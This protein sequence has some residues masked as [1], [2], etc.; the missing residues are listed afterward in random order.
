MPRM[1]SISVLL[2]IFS[3]FPLFSIWENEIEIIICIKERTY[4]ARLVINY[5][6]YAI[7][8]RSAFDQIYICTTDR[9]IGICGRNLDAAN[10]LI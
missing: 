10:T 4:R 3:L 7:M 2:D 9:Q 1:L 6:C 5:Y 8:T